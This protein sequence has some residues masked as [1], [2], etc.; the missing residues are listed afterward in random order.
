LLIIT[1]SCK[2]NDNNTT[3]VIGDWQNRSELDGISRSE[4]VS[5]VIGDS[6]YL[7]TGYDG[8]NRLHDLWQYDP[9][10]DSWRQKADLPGTPRSSAVGFTINNKGYVGTGYDGTNRL[11][12]FWQY[13]PTTNSWAKKADFAGSARYDAVGFAVMDKGYISTGFDG[14]Y[15]KDLWQYDDVNDSWMQMISMG[16]A[17]RSGAVA[18]VHDNKAYICTGNNNGVTSTVTDVWVFDPTATPYWSEKRRI[19]NLD[20]DTYDDNYTD[21]TRTNAT[22]FV[23]GD[24]AFLATGNTGGAVATCWQ[25]DFAQDV[26]VKKTDFENSAREGAVGFSVSNRGFIATGRSGNSPFDDIMEFLPDAPY[27]ANN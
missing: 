21:I 5:F 14:N 3:T 11:N 23:I 7:A 16:G 18:F 17:K 24:F 1:P 27:Q 9:A 19:A 26:W 12:D 10:L 15:L 8:T 13:N 4:A 22:A 2:N 25:Y 6:A 20:P